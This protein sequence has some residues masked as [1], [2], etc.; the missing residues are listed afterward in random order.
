MLTSVRG[1]LAATMLAGSLFAAAP[2]LAQEE[3]A[4]TISG[5]AAVV[6]EYRFRGVD[7]SGGD[8]AI[9][10]GI[11]AGH[12]SGV[13]VGVWGSS[14]DEDSVGYGH[15]EVDLY[16][17]FKTEIGALGTIDVG[18]TYYLYPNAGPG[19]FDVIE[20]YTKL[21]LGIGPATAT[22][23]VAYSPKQDSLDF[24]GP[25]DNLYLSGDLGAGLPGTPISISAHL[26]YTDGALTYTNDST[27]FDWSIGA[28]LAL[29]GTPLSVGVSYVDADGTGTAAYP[30]VD[31]AVVATL[32]A[33]F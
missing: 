16:G 26:G 8:I 9:Q 4:I 3:S 1:L 32:T 6:S 10:G 30:F 2:A 19:D 20:F 29:P 27:A 17:G 28:A 33:S 7:L 5:N 13:Y 15:T 18:M 25:R 22:L 11:T 24:G 12:D 31:D 21:G 14:L 23:G